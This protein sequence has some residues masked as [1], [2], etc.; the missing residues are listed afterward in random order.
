MTY[1]ISIFILAVAS[2]ISCAYGKTFSFL[3]FIQQDFIKSDFAKSQALSVQIQEKRVNEKQG[4]FYPDL[5]LNSSVVYDHYPDGASPPKDTVYDLSLELNQK[6]YS[7]ADSRASNLEKARLALIKQQRQISED[8]LLLKILQLLLKLQFQNDLLVST[9][10]YFENVKRQERQ[11]ATK[12]RVGDSTRTDLAQA[13]AQTLEVEMD[14]QDLLVEIR[15]TQK[16]LEQLL[17]GRTVNAVKRLDIANCAAHL[18]DKENVSKMGINKREREQYLKISLQEEK[19]KQESA[20]H[21]PT[22]SL[23]A[24]LNKSRSEWQDGENLDQSDAQVGIRF[25]LPLYSGGTTSNRQM[26]ESIALAREKL[27]A[28]LLARQLE[29]EI[30]VNFMMIRRAREKL[31]SL[32]KV[33]TQKNIILKGMETSF[34]L[35]AKEIDDVLTAETSLFRSQREKISIKNELENYTLNSLVLSGVFSPSYVLQ[36]V[37]EREEIHL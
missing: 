25:T 11:A 3:H 14:H 28:K 22:L 29:Y 18:E 2:T 6:I 30:D 24:S 27:Q 15:E 12:V 23:F 19:K 9:E 32:E 13:M 10:K 20:H 17:E 16:M 7:A 21:W 36:C 37:K 5:S 34:R 26:A 4:R 33:I 8:E 31:S 1:C 35:G